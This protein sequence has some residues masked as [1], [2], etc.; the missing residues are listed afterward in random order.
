MW[1]T[2]SFV[3]EPGMLVLYPGRVVLE[4][5]IYLICYIYREIYH[6]SSIQEQ[7]RRAREEKGLTQAE[8]GIRLGQPQ[9][10][11]SR[12][13]RGGD[14]R[15][16][17]VLEIA[18]TLD[19]EPMLIPK[20]LVPAVRALIQHRGGQELEVPGPSLVG[21]VQEDAEEAID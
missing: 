1:G 2:P 15:L 7:I 17:T 9:S 21:G 16:S 5:R 19:L 11:V 13:E 8:L 10:S 3:R 4:K 14:V 20:R 12:V 6:M 18:R